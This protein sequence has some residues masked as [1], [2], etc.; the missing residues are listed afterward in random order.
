MAGVMN[1]GQRR[2]LMDQVQQGLQIASTV[3]GIK[4]QMD[5]K[6]FRDEQRA[7]TEKD[8]E[9]FAGGYLDKGQQRELMLTKG[10]AEAKEGEAGAYPIYDKESRSLVGYVKRQEAPKIAKGQWVETKDEKGNP[11]R[12]Y[13]AD[14]QAGETL[15]VYV[16]PT[17]PGE[18]KTPSNTADL[19]K[20]YNSQQT[21]KSTFGVVESY[22]KIQQNIN[23]PKPTGASDMSLV[24]SFMKMNDPNSTVREGEYATAENSGG[25]SDKI[26]NMYNKMLNGERLSPEQRQNFAAEAEGLLAAQL[27]A[28]EAVDQRYADIATK[29]G[30][31]PQFVVEPSFAKTKK[32]LGVAKTKPQ[33]QSPGEAFAGPGGAA[34]GPSLDDI[35]AELARR[36]VK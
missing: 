35:Q 4:S 19:R 12:K 3:Y 13:V 5:E 2:T 6:D 34:G 22:K 25:V 36:G 8:K 31:D 26:R 1:P 27:D 20:E 24:Y 32:G 7:K 14:P 29:F 21:T 15:P 11:I 9:D 30:L 16:A 18:D 33:G 28:Q 17:K 10:L 23:N